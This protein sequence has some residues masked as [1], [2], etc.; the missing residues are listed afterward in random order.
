MKPNAVICDLDNTLFDSRCMEKYIP[1]DNSR[2]GWDNFH[3]H[4][5]ECVI[6]KPVYRLLQGFFPDTLIIFCLII[7]SDIF[8]GKIVELLPIQ[9]LSPTKVGSR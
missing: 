2:E 8:T 7:L 4:Y 9:T 5:N 6:N 1:K 3:K